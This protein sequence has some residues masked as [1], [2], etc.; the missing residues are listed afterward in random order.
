MSVI[1]NEDN[2]KSNGGNVKTSRY[3]IPA[4][5]RKDK[6]E[7]SFEKA[8]VIALILHPLIVLILILNFKYWIVMLM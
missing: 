8:L 6:E 7:I 4:V 5:I 3:E 1:K 2:I